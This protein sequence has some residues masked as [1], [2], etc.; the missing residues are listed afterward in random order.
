MNLTS[1]PPAIFFNQEN[2]CMHHSQAD[3]KKCMH[4]RQSTSS[5]LQM[6]CDVFVVVTR[7]NACMHKENA[8]MHHSQ[9][10][11]KPLQAALANRSSSCVAARQPLASRSL[12]ARQPLASRS[13]AARQPLSSRSP[14]ARQ[15]HASRSQAAHQPLHASRSPAAVALV[16]AQASA[17]RHACDA[18]FGHCSSVDPE[19]TQV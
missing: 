19:S 12:A 9:A 8:C 2:A 6:K 3:R 15:P 10:A 7:K 11:R 4:V 16:V 17:A 1:H 18:A 13:P 5:R 14:A